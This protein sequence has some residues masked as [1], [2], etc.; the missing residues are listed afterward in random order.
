[1]NPTKATAEAEIR[2]Q[3]DSWLHAV[4]AMDIEAIVSH[5]ASDIPAFDAVSQLQ[6]K[7]VD[8]Y[9]RHWQACLAMC[10]PGTMI[11]EVHDVHVT[12]GDDVAF[13][14]AL[15]RCG[16]SGA[17]GDAK[18]GWRRMTAEYRQTHGKWMVVPEPCMVGSAARHRFSA[19]HAVGARLR[20]SGHPSIRLRFGRR[21]MMPS[22]RRTACDVSVLP[23]HRRRDAKADGRPLTRQSRTPLP[24]GSQRRGSREE[25]GSQDVRCRRWMCGWAA[26]GSRLARQEGAG[27]L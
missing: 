23:K 6:F 17:N 3:V 5:Y 25:S 27:A 10:R 8:A 14:T 20:Q 7:G 24:I 4:L 18:A 11:F 21:P 19:S 16:G 15:T 26:R 12:A 13:A 22:H 2:A 9:R 1:M